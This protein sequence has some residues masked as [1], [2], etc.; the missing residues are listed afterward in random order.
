M[1]NILWISIPC[2][3]TECPMFEDGVG[4]PFVTFFGVFLAGLF[5]LF[6]V[7]MFIDQICCI[8]DNTSTIDNLKRGQETCGN[9]RTGWQNMKEVFGGKDKDFSLFEWLWPFTIQRKL[10]I[11]GEFD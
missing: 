4:A 9:S 1:F 7:C 6:V 2:T 3:M 5:D 11:E 10:F 8:V